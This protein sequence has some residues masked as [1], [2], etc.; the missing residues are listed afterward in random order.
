VTVDPTLLGKL[1]DKLDLGTRQVNRL[2]SERART[3]LISREDAAVALALESKVSVPRRLL[4][5]DVLTTIRTAGGSSSNPPPPTTPP[6]AG[7]TT[8]KKAARK[9]P[10]AK[11]R[12]VPRKNRKKVFVVHGRDEARRKSMF[13]LLRAMKLEPIEW[14]EAVK[15]TGKAAPYIGEVLDKAFLDAAAVVVLLTPDD[16]ARLKSTL[17]K[18]KDPKYESTLTGQARANVLFEAGMAFGRHQESTVLVQVGD[19]RPFSDIGGRHVVNLDNT[20]LTRRDLANRLQTAGC[21]VNLDGSD[22]LTEGDFE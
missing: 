18:V 22:W 1:E 13:R 12:S 15:A 19:L 20:A 6:P 8:R 9:R 17:R 21:D 11:K 2:I 16:Q 7:R 3:L 10:T 14:S 5:P 4:T